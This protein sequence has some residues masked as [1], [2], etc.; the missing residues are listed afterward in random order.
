MNR[1]DILHLQ[2]VEKYPCLSILLPTHRVTTETRQDMLRVKNLVAEAKKRLAQEFHDREISSL[3]LRLDEVVNNL[4][5]EHLLDGL[6][7]FVNNDTAYTFYLPFSPHERVI[8][9]HTFA[10]RDLIK[11]LHHTQRYWVLSLSEK[12]TR[13]YEGSG[14]TLIEITKHGFP[15]TYTGPGG[16]GPLPGGKGI[17]PSIYLEERHKQFFGWVDTAFRRIAADDPLPLVV[18]GVD[19]YLA[20]FQANSTQAHSIIA[21]LKGNYDHMSP[22][23]LGQLVWPLVE[24][25]LRE[26]NHTTIEELEAAVGAG[27]YAA[28]MEAVW[29]MAK[30]GRGATLLVEDNFTYPAHVDQTGYQISPASD[31][32]KPGVIDDAVDEVIEIVMQKGGRVV[33]VDEGALQQYQ[34]IALILRY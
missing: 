12:P 25:Q 32:T 30:E 10:T 28:T 20:Y 33:M 16:T 34:H 6:A 11:S 21:T 31:P 4:D 19:R 8:V 3:L 7:I 14:P 22:H 1:Q 17:E 29:R 23:D 5:Y 27:K 26:R 13:L 24:K 9:D 15:M 18:V 2:V